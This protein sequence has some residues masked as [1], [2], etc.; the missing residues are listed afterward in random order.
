M[1]Q[2]D[3]GQLSWDE[4]GPTEI[5]CQVYLSACGS[6]SICGPS[7]VLGGCMAGY[8]RS[9]IAMLSVVTLCSALR[10]NPVARP[11]YLPH[12][13]AGDRRVDQAQHRSRL[14]T[15]RLL[16]RFELSF[17]QCQNGANLSSRRDE[18][19]SELGVEVSM[20]CYTICRIAQF[21]WPRP[22]LNQER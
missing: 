19:R 1:T 20:R 22:L 11:T 5:D 18:R 14:A 4:G 12:H 8:V 15:G 3:N 13:A 10:S 9:R 17:T 7:R 21:E 16:Q 2:G 6:N